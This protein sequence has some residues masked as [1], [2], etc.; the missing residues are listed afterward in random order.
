MKYLFIHIL[1]ALSKDGQLKPK[2]SVWLSA[3]T[4]LSVSTLCWVGIIAEFICFYLLNKAFVPSK[5]GSITLFLISFGIFYYSL[6]KD[7]KHELIIEEY[8]NESSE[9]NR[10]GKILTFVY[11]FSPMILFM[12]LA[13][14]RTN[15]I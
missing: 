5:A 14:I 4:F 15:R 6:V 8:Q 11:I 10:F 13:M 7:K 9:K 12:L 2:H 1:N 3:L